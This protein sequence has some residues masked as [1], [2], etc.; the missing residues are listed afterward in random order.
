MYIDYISLK[1]F[2]QYSNE[3]IVFGLPKKE[4]NF[5]IIQGANG[6]GKT[7][8]MNAICWCLYGEELHIKAQYRG[9]PLVNISTLQKLQ[10]RESCDV[11]VEIQMIE[12]D[13]KILFVRSQRYRKSGSGKPERI[14]HP[15][16]TSKDGSRF[17][18]MRQIRRNW[19][20]VP[21]PSYVLGGLIPKS[22]REYFFFDGE[23]LNEYFRGSTSQSIQEAVFKLAQVNLLERTIEHLT[24]VSLDYVRREKVLTPKGDEI[25]EKLEIFRDAYDEA[26]AELSELQDQKNGAEEKEEE[27][28]KQLR[29]TS[30]ENIAQL[31]EERVE[32]ESDIKDLESEIENLER[33]WFA[34]LIDYTPSIIGR[35]MLSKTAALIGA[36]EEAGDIP[37]D[38]KK[39]FLGKLLKS[40]KCICG[41]DL[42]A[43]HKCREEVTR[44]LVECD[45]I[46]DISEELTMLHANVEAML[47]RLPEFREKQ[48][49]YGKRIKKLKQ[50]KARKIKRV[51]VI[52]ER[53]KNSDVERIKKLEVRRNK[54][55]QIRERLISQIAIKSSKLK[56]AEQEIN[57]LNREL[58]EELEKVEKF[59]ELRRCLAFCEDTLKAAKEIKDEIV[60]E[61]LRDVERRTRKEFFELIWKKATYKDVKIDANY[62]VSVIH[63]SGLE[64]IGSLSAGERQVLALAFMAALNSVSGFN[65]P[66]IIDT[67]LGRISRE[68]KENIA[69]NLPNYLK[70]KQVI[71]LVTEEEYTPEIREKLAKRVSEEYL[72]EFHEAE[73]IAKVVPFGD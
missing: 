68:P 43:K 8:L 39:R 62:N 53:I 14:P 41:T 57:K 27:C 37:P 54:W 29:T 19:V 73:N 26:K 50:D 42:L 1:N 63:K 12:G 55:R 65:V 56:G 33:D 58:K 25:R 17:A 59:S 40:G 2:R 35:K 28:S 6:A 71:L 11:E 31:E 3:R 72:I 60:E 47:E 70:D 5:T 34:F 36:R 64:S 67:P 4:T 38:F 18:M 66:I 13:E 16:S 69:R 20:E 7:N 22:I 45:E 32:L 46:S 23:R 30:P 52:G 44:L 48:L 21:D 49:D 51:E 61:V 9:L 15:S 24:R 10:P